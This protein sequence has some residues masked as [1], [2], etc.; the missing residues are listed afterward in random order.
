MYKS[1]LIGS[2]HEPLSRLKIEYAM[3]ENAVKFKVA[4]AFLEVYSEICFTRSPEIGVCTL[5]SKIV[6]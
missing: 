1:H 5:N 6:T 4:L 2:D 3:L